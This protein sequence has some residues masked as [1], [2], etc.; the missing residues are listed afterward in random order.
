[1]AQTRTPAKFHAPRVAGTTAPLRQKPVR[2]E[3]MVHFVPL[4]VDKV[5][6]E[7]A[8]MIP[9]VDVILG[10]LEDA[11][12]AEEKEAA[13]YGFIDMARAH[14]YT[15]TG[16][17]TRINALN[18]PWAL[19][20]ICE[21]SAAA[22]DKLD[23]VMLPKV[24]GPWEIHYLRK[25]MAQ[26]EIKYGLSHP[27]MIHVILETAEGVNNVE[28]IAGPSP[29][30]HGMSIGPAN[31][32]ATRR[33]ETMRT[34]G[35]HP[36]PGG[37]SHPN[38]GEQRRFSRQD[39][40]HHTMG[41]MVDACA[42]YDLKPFYAPFGDFSNPQGCEAQLRSAF[43]QGCAGAWSLHPDQIE[44]AKRAFSPAAYEVAFAK[45]ILDSMPDGSGAVMVD[46]EMHDDTTW[47]QAKDS[48]DLARLVAA[49]DPDMA[50][51]YGL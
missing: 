4:H 14:D 34:G 44:I 7:I 31:L 11:V 12:P 29:R 47:K 27:V 2:L 28:A 19:D 45:R 26:L 5:R 40:V 35:A 1:M 13:R 48:I 25:S 20:D 24:E 42:E 46:G 37:P 32:A 43:L 21:I 49:K 38:E 10:N 18:S 23:V 36:A 39:L 9:Q 50:P 16:L 30:I 8:D 17:W 6:A 51:V 33:M 22:G 15:D 41:R 3:R